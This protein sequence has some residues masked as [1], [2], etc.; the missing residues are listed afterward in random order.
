M[1]SLKTIL[2][3][4]SPIPMGPIP[5]HLSTL[6]DAIQIPQAM[7]NSSLDLRPVA[8]NLGL[9][10]IQSYAQERGITLKVLE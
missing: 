3:K 8:I 1:N 6:R 7:Q 2:D 5:I 10:A 4:T 9:S